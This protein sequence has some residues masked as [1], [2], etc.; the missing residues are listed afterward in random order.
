M[1]SRDLDLRRRASHVELRSLFGGVAL[2]DLDPASG[3]KI[4]YAS[5][6]LLFF[7]TWRACGRDTVVRRTHGGGQAVK[8]HTMWR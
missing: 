6:V 4:E 8:T 2:Y 3:T 5:R 7:S 1:L